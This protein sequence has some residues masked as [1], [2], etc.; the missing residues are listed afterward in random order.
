MLLVQF[1][2]I[3]MVRFTP[4]NQVLVSVFDKAICFSLFLTF[5]FVLCLWQSYILIFV[6]VLCLW[7]SY[8]L[9][10]AAN[11]TSPK[12]F[13]DLMIVYFTLR[14]RNI[15]PK[16]LHHQYKHQKRLP[17][18]QT[19]RRHLNQQFCPPIALHASSMNASHSLCANDNPPLPPSPS[20]LWFYSSQLLEWPSQRLRLTSRAYRQSPSMRG[21]GRCM[22]SSFPVE[23]PNT[24]FVP[25]LANDCPKLPA[26]TVLEY[27]STDA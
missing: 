25:C 24:Q 21:N 6:F 9:R 26:I 27:I 8:M 2:P 12:T 13:V 5:V 1:K 7:Q 20:S 16:Y 18:K 4:N 19:N 15:L 10:D 23:R 17:K 14:L 22:I 3:R 11:P